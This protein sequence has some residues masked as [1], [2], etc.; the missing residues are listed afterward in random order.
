M[1]YELNFTLDLE[2]TFF[3]AAYDDRALQC[4]N[5]WEESPKNGSYVV[6]VEGSW[7]K[8]NASNFE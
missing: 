4:D 7:Q 6:E 8:M 1:L 3:F 5:I 2:K